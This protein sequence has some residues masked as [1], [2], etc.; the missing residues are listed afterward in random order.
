MI[1]SRFL[2]ASFASIFAAAIVAGCSENPVDAARPSIDVGASVEIASQ[3]VQSFGGTIVIDMPNEPLDGMVLDIPDGAYDD[4]RT[5]RVSSAPITGH[6]FGDDFKPLTPLITIENGGGYSDEPM[7]LSVPVTVP[8]GHFAMAFLYDADTRTLEALPMLYTDSTVVETMTRNFAHSSVSALRKGK[9]AEGE[10]SSILIAAT[11]VAMLETTYDSKFVVGQDNFQFVNWG[12]YV[13]PGGHCGGQTIAAMWYHS[14]KNRNGSPNLYGLYDNDG[15]DK[16]PKIW[17]DDEAAFRFCS[18]V[19]ERQNWSSIKY[20]GDKSWDRDL[21]TYRSIAFAIRETSEPQCLY[22]SDGTTAHAILAV[23]TSAGTIGVCD[24]NFPTQDKRTI[25]FDRRL[26]DFN[27]YYSGAN[28]GSRGTA[29]FNIH[30]AANSALVDYHEVAELWNQ[31]LDGTI[32]R[33]VFPE[34]QLRV[35]NSNNDYVP[36]TDGLIVP[37]QVTLD[38]TS[39]NFAPRFR[40][41]LRNGEVMISDNERDFTL[42][43]G[44]HRL[45]VYYKGPGEFM[46]GEY[47]GFKWVNVEVV[48]DSPTEE[49]PTG[50]WFKGTL[51]LDGIRSN[52]SGQFGVNNAATPPG[53]HLIMRFMH[54]GGEL[55]L[56]L[57]FGG[58]GT[59]ALGGTDSFWSESGKAYYAQSGSTLTV[60]EWAGTR[61]R[62]SVA[63]NGTTAGGGTR[64]ITASFE[65]E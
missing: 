54:P 16:T 51:D 17:Y 60:T 31:V 19:H 43:K 32:G 34:V 64:V 29:Y 6:A 47:V 21:A 25:V 48:E 13:A 15:V 23:S 28:A 62:G 44:K 4:T 57:D 36:L 3:V 42:P 26:G 35:R 41:F 65:E 30:A 33:D 59:Y 40:V 50:L 11:D 22:V 24:P 1:R 20:Y 18:V 12:S 7:L 5:F 45:G 56:R 9:S 53:K 55:N 39:Q 27:P 38:V 61:F 49:G 52:I 14:V 63:F 58:K 2:V 37:A 10:R 8:A 46:D